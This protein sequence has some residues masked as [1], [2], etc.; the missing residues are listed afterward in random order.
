MSTEPNKK[1]ASKHANSGTFR[2]GDGRK[3]ERS[4]QGTRNK[5]ARECK[6]MIATCFENIG[7]IDGLTKWAKE[8]PSEFYCRMYVRLIGVEVDAKSDHRQVVYNTIEQIND[9]LG[10]HGLTLE[11]LERLRRYE[12][13]QPKLIEHVKVD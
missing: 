2:K 1:Q 4:R 11:M 12:E 8:N 13:A 10:P 5:M 7:G 9:A 6:E 3:A